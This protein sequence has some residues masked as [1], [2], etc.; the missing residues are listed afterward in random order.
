MSSPLYRTQLCKHGPACI[1]PRCMFA[2]SLTDI[3]APPP[4]NGPIDA[5]TKIHFY[6]GQA[7]DQEMVNRFLCY[8]RVTPMIELPIWALPALW[9]FL[10]LHILWQRFAGRDFGLSQRVECYGHHLPIMV[11][12]LRHKLAL[13]LHSM[14]KDSVGN[15]LGMYYNGDQSQSRRYAPSPPPPRSISPALHPEEARSSRRYRRGS[16][17]RSIPACQET[18]RS[19]SRS[20]SPVTAIPDRRTPKRHQRSRSPMP[21]RSSPSMPMPRRQRSESTSTT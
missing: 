8:A 14:G 1:H 15:V 10:D 6:I 16:S 3:R 11:D 7:W 18:G 20:A 4:R 19:S 12:A 21:A 2:H 9:L 17:R 5:W 13:R